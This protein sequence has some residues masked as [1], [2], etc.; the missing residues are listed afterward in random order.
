M[1]AIIPFDI[2]ASS[3]YYVRNGKFGKQFVKE[4][5][6][7]QNMN[8]L[9]GIE[10]RISPQDKFH[11]HVER[12]SSKEG[13]K[14]EL[15][16]W[17]LWKNAGIPTLDFV[18]SSGNKI[19]W[20][21]LEAPSLRLYLNENSQT[22][23]ESVFDKYLKVYSNTKKLV[24]ENDNQD[25]FHNDPWLKNYLVSSNEVIPIDPG[26]NLRR[27]LSIGELEAAL[28]RISLCSIV[29]LSVE[30]KNKRKYIEMFRASLDDSEAKKVMDFNSKNSLWFDLYFGL[31]EE[32]V[33]R[34]KKR[35]K[36]KNGYENFENARKEYL[37]DIFD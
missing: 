12:D 35:T 26:V 8:L 9:R 33:S 11:R 36:I 25:F 37:N 3:T 13:Y 5:I 31:R 16:T 14:Q 21:Y 28:N 27:D 6:V 1:D 15:K 24:K 7:G 30:E 23:E 19:V 32:I 2:G 17:G 29:D 18:E 4:Y 34:L 20:N 22:F 10:K